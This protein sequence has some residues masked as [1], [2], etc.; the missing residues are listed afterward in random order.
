MREIQ[1]LARGLQIINLMSGIES[2]INVTDIAAKL[3]V[4][5]ST[6]SRLLGTL[7]SYGYVQRAKESRAYTMG[8]RLHSISWQLTN[9][10]ALRELARPYLIKLAQATGECA[11]IGV[12][13]EGK[14]LV[15]DDIQPETSQLRVVS[16]TGRTLYLHNTALGKG[17]MAFADLP[18]PDDLPRITPGTI[19]DH[20]Q[21]IEELRITRQRGYALDDEENEYGVRCLAAPVYNA[22]GLAIATIG[23]SGPTVRVHDETI[24]RLVNEVMYAAFALSQELGYE[25]ET[26]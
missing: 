16:Q 22:I 9:R 10:F 20:N 19:T 12:Y 11:H 13:S 17:L 15:T 5:K 26:A 1:S 24:D 7:E 14:A 3:D 4:D 8:K 2:P 23:I 21:L 25:P 6:A 18:L